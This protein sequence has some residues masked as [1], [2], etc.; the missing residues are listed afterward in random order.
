MLD[1]HN[2]KSARGLIVFGSGV[3]YVL[4][5]VMMEA[6]VG[7]A[8]GDLAS[9]PITQALIGVGILGTFISACLIPL[10]MHYWLA[11]GNQYRVGIFFWLAD[12]AVLALNAATAYQLIKSM[13]LDGFFAMWQLALPFIGPAV[14]ILGWGIVYLLDE[15]QKDRHADRLLQT[16]K[17]EMQ[18]VAA[19]TR[20]NAEHGFSM[21]QIAQ[22][23]QSLTLALQSPHIAALAQQGANEAALRLTRQITGMPI[24]VAPVD[25]YAMTVT[26]PV[27]RGATPTSQPTMID[28]LDTIPL[29]ATGAGSNGN[30]HHPNG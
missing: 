29:V 28:L 7:M 10:A 18:R 13:T 11:P 12:L 5:I 24:G 9:S 14:C 25:A 23:E 22:V 16:S 30:G 6:L 8:L 20:A 1:Q 26:S 15:S 27:P 21:A 19:M 4:S 17:N 3:A 2:Q